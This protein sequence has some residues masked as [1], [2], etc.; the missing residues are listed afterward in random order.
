MF[1]QVYDPSAAYEAGRWIVSYYGLNFRLARKGE[2]FAIPGSA[3]ASHEIDPSQT[4]TTLGEAQQ[5]AD[6]RNGALS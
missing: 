2:R 3:Q 5:A 6:A 1:T 4:F